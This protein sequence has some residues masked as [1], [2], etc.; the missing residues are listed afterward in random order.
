V[1]YAFRRNDRPR[2]VE[3]YLTL[4]DALMRN[5]QSQKARAVYR[6]RSSR[7]RTTCRRGPR[8][9]RFAPPDRSRC[10]PPARAGTRPP[11]QGLRRWHAHERFRQ[12][13]RLASRR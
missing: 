4:A 13:G 9:K 12:S 6:P 3:A 7:P 5:E 2:L 8:W 11:I 10:R 1:E